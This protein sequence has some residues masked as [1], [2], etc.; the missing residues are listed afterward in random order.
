M[1]EMCEMVSK[2]LR[3]LDHHGRRSNDQNKASLI[4]TSPLSPIVLTTIGE[5]GMDGDGGG[6]ELRLKQSLTIAVFR[7]LY[8]FCKCMLKLMKKDV[9][10]IPSVAEA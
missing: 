7:A 4:E 9:T 5:G 8:I 6:M 3:K 10:H 1:H 2:C